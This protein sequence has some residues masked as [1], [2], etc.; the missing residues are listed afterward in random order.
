MLALESGRIDVTVAVLMYTLM[1]GAR[2]VAVTCLRADKR[3]GMYSVAVVSSGSMC[4]TFADRVAGG[5]VLPD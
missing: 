3:F 4:I 5:Y 2:S 1:V